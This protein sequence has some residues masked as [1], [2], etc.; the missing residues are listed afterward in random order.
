MERKPTDIMEDEHRVILRTVDMMAALAKNLEAGRPV[1]ADVLRDIVHF[2]RMYA[3][4][5][6]HGK[7]ETHLFTLLAA[8]G[9]PT[10]GCP[11]GALTAEHQEGRALV[12][13]LAQAVETYAAAVPSTHEALVQSLH[14]LTELYP[15]H[16]WKEDFLLF[17]MTNK[18]LSPEDQAALYERFEA[19][20][21]ALGRDLHRQF[22]Q[23]VAGLEQRL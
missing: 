5:Y 13:E 14:G 11:L 8:R 20:D 17:P 15:N 9:V 18:V 19:V 16:I 12:T 21:D 2:L 10:Q 7:E 3:D 23:M 22:E 1:E 6:H 4:K